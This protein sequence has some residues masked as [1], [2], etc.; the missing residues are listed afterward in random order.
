[1][2]IADELHKTLFMAKMASDINMLFECTG[3]FMGMCCVL[4]LDGMKRNLEKEDL[5]ASEQAQKLLASITEEQKQRAVENQKLLAALVN[6]SIA[7]R[8]VMRNN[9]TTKIKVAE[10]EAYAEKKKTNNNLNA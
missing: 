5:F 4:D 9:E 2:T 8:D 1:M 3:D 7:F 10:L 6:A